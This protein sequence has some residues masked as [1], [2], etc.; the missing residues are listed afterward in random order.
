ME[1]WESE[2]WEAYPDYDE[3]AVLEMQLPGTLLE[4]GSKRHC[5]DFRSIK[6]VAQFYAE[7]SQKPV[8]IYRDDAGWWCFRVEMPLPMAEKRINEKRARLKAD[9]AKR[10]SELA[11]LP[12]KEDLPGVMSADR[13][14]LRCKTREDAAL[15]ARFFELTSGKSVQI[16]P[17]TT[18]WAVE[19]HEPTLKELE[20]ERARKSLAKVARMHNVELTDAEWFE[21]ELQWEIE[22]IDEQWRQ[23]RDWRFI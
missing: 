17:E 23:D 5:T 2:I 20:A 13:S 21:R 22:R 18:G 14:L 10:Q 3:P 4:D 19:T 8:D 1:D 12:A 9:R 15:A 7:V 11:K 6:I 16:W